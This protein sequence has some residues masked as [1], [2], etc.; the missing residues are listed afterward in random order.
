MAREQ[1]F[2]MEEEFAGLDCNSS[3]LEKRFV[4]TKGEARLRFCGSRAAVRR[5]SIY[6]PVMRWAGVHHYFIIPL[7]F[8]PFI[9]NSLISLGICSIC[10]L[11]SESINPP[12]IFIAFNP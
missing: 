6:S 5:R 8:N 2:N 1:A 3:R 9:T 4:R 7:F 12:F 11:S 10:Q